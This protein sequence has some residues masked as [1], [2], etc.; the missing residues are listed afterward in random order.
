MFS[1]VYGNLI[2]RHFGVNTPQPALVNISQSF[3][4]AMGISNQTRDIPLAPGQGVGCEY[5]RGLAPVVP[6]ASRNNEEDA[7]IQAIYGVHLLTQNPDRRI[8]KPNCAAYRGGIFAFDFELTFSFLLPLIGSQPDP[9]AVD[10]QGIGKR[11]LFYNDLRT[12]QHELDWKPFLRNLEAL[13]VARMVDMFQ[14]LPGDWREYA[15]RVMAHIESV[16]LHPSK[17]EDALRRSLL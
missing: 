10:E 13:T 6:I 16:R 2:A 7:H 8:D 1:E 4:D 12:R 17:F 3:V 9:W 15:D 5:L 11:H 14:G